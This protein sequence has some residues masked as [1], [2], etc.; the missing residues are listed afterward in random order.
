LTSIQVQTDAPDSIPDSASGGD[1]LATSLFFRYAEYRKFL[2]YLK[3]LGATIPLCRWDGSNAIILRHDVDFDL[4]AAHRLALI[5]VEHGIRSTYFI[6]TTSHMYN[7]ASL[8]KR[9]KL[10]EMSRLGFEIGLHFDPAVYGNADDETMR[11]HV[12]REAGILSAITGMQVRSLSLHNPS[13]DG[14]YPTYDGYHNAYQAEIFSDENYLSDSRMDFRGKDPYEFVLRVRERPIQILLH[15]IH[16]SESG[17]AYPELFTRM[18]KS[19]VEQVDR[20]ARVNS[21]YRR[22]MATQRLYDA[23]SG[24][25]PS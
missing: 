6:L 9:K 18:I 21:T 16:Y 11:A 5:E 13:V 17:D 24:E 23:V 1:R 3:P 22:Q 19:H 10:A 12:D 20:E 8:D 7:P 4:N 2:R 14:R 25:T 15:P